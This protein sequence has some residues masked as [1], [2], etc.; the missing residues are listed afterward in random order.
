MG[1][2]FYYRHIIS[3]NQR[4]LLANLASCDRLFLDFNSII[5]MCAG[6]VIGK[7]RDLSSN[8]EIYPAIFEEVFN[9]TL[10]LTTICT[11]RQLLYIAI[12]GVAPR[13]KIQQ[14]R[15]RR[16]LS[17]YRNDIINTFKENNNM[18]FVKWDSNC[19]TPGTKFMDALHA[20]LEKRLIP[21]QTSFGFKIII[22][23]ACDIG[24]GEQKI[25]QY[26][27]EVQ[28][29]ENTVDVIYGLD[30]DLIMLSLCCTSTAKIYLMREGKDFFTGLSDYKYLDTN[31]LKTSIST[32]FNNSFYDYVFICFI[33]GNDFLPNLS[34]LKIKSGAVDI[35]C[36]VYKA[37]FEKTNQNALCI[38]GDTYY[39]NYEFL[40]TFFEQLANK[41]DALMKTTTEQ[42]YDNSSSMRPNNITSKLEK[43]TQ[44]LDNYPSLN[45]FPKVIDPTT[46]TAWRSSYYHHLF[47]SHQYELIK[48]V[49]HNYV[50]GLVWNVNYYFNGKFDNMWYF[51]YNYAPCISDLYNYVRMLQSD[52]F[53]STQIK[54]MNPSVHSEI[55][56]QIQLLMVLPP[57]SKDILD[58]NI[59]KIMSDVQYGC[60]HYY[61]T[62]FC[63]TT[64]LKTHLWECI[65]VLPN[66]NVDL[67][68]KAYEKVKT[69]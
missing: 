44:E 38:E 29:P 55:T 24:E 46:D 63:L 68:K 41:E 13:S 20:Y 62:K 21:L 3:K 56:P 15:K 40:S 34:C 12:D 57:F 49:C 53:R 45:K 37:T 1:I 67:I 42:F 35:L 32:Y 65:P 14:Q 11:P 4:K 9:H 36:D 59:Q 64:Y 8:E 54:L 16:F 30:A 39:V 19:I 18:K 31:A 66:I 22:S 58:E 50:E 2:P 43:F 52:V 51:R 48:Q 5:H 61:P 27:K 17:A 28:C 7:N 25:F 26:M 23:G 6:N 47:G 33:L 69:K 10:L 60:C